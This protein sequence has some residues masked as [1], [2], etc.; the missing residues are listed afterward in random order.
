MP[1]RKNLVDFLREDLGL[2]GSHV[3]CE[4]GVCGACTLEVDGVRGDAVDLRGLEHGI[5]AELDVVVPRAIAVKAAIVSDDFR[6]SGRRA[7][8]NFGH[9]IGHGIEAAG[10]YDLYHHGE[11]ISLG[12]LAALRIAEHVCGLPG[13]WRERTVVVLERHG[14]KATMFVPTGRILHDHPFFA[15]WKTIASHAGSGRWN[16]QSHGHHA[17]DP[18][19]VSCLCSICGLGVMVVVLPSPTYA[20][21]PQMRAQSRALLR[22][23][24]L[25]E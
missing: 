17:H 2:T 13:Q 22:A 7:L 3:G 1:V 21:R 19:T 15:D 9:T 23:V 4:H 11:A 6:E 16:L 8:L 20:T 5:D 24:G 10:G 25:P 14:L 12:L 18:I